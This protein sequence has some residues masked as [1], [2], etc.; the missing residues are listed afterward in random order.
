MREGTDPTKEETEVEEWTGYG[1]VYILSRTTTYSK[2]WRKLRFYVVFLW[3]S[4]LCLEQW[5]SRFSLVRQP[6]R[7]VPELCP[8]PFSFDPDSLYRIHTVRSTRIDPKVRRTPKWLNLWNSP[9]IRNL[10]RDQ[11]TVD[12]GPSICTHVSSGSPTLGLFFPPAPYLN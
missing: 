10:D 1:F 2:F 4:T 5:M 9:R 12:R 3:V 6:S 7:C 11:Q 8:V